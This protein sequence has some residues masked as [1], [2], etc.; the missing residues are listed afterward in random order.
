MIKQKSKHR[1]L[2]YLAIVIFIIAFFLYGTVRIVN[3]PRTLA[4]ALKIANLKS[5]WK[6]HLEKF[7][8]T[9][10]SHQIELKNILSTSEGSDK[11]V[12]ASRVFIKYNPWGL[13]R[14]KI[15]IDNLE[16]QNLLLNL[17]K[18]SGTASFKEHKRLN[19]TKLVLL[20]NIELKKCNINDLTMLFRADNFLNAKNVAL[21][22]VPHI[23]GKTELSVTANNIS[24]IV[25]EEKIFAETISID[26][27][28]NLSRWLRHFPYINSISGDLKL[29]NFGMND[30]ISE[31]MDAH[32]SFSDSELELKDFAISIKGKTLNGHL[33]ANTNNENFDLGIDIAKPIELPYI[34]RQL[35]TFD[36]GGNLSAEIV[37]EGH[38]FIPSQTNGVGHIKIIHQFNASPE[39]PI[40]TVTDVAWAK[41]TISLN[42]GTVKALA[43][44]A[45]FSG[46]IDVAKKNFKIEA[47]GE[48]FPIELVFD[49]FTEPHL[50]KI[51]G[52]TDFH[53]SIEGWGKKFSAKITG[54]TF[55][56][57]WQPF[58]VERIEAEFEATY[59][60]LKLK[61][62]IFSDTKKTGNALLT[63]K[64]GPKIGKQIRHKQVDF[65]ASLTDH[66]CKKSLSALK[67][68]GTGTGKIKI[69]GPVTSI[70]GESEGIITKGNWNNIPFERIAT[71]FDFSNHTFLFSEMDLKIPNTNNISIP[72][73][74]AGK[75]SPDSVKF[76]GSLME[77]S[78]INT[79]YRLKDKKWLI[80]KIEWND[81]TSSDNHLVLGGS[82]I[83]GGAIDMKIR[84]STDIAKLFFIS[85][86]ARTYSGMIDT[87]ITLRGS[88]S[89]P[90]PHGFITFHNN[91]LLPRSLPLVLE[92]LEG[93]IKLD[94]ARIYLDN[95]RA[96]V[97]DGNLNFSGY[98]DHSN[99]K[100][101]YFDVQVA[102][103]AMRYRSNDGTLN[104]E[105]DGSIKLE[106]DA[107]DPILKG[108]MAIQ[109]GRYT[110]DF[111]LIDAF[112]GKKSEKRHK[113]RDE[114]PLSINPRLDLRVSNTGDLLIRNNVGDIWL[115]T[116]IVVKGT[117]DKPIIAGTV[118]TQEGKIHYLGSSFDITRGFVEFREKYKEPYLEVYA[119]KEINAYNINLVLHGY[120]DNLALDLSATSP[121]GI[122]EKRDVVS[123]MLFGATEQ[124][125]IAQA[126]QSGSKLPTSI[127]A[128]SVAG[129]LEKPVLKL[130]HFDI[131]RLEA[132]DPSKPS[133]SRLSLG[134]QVTD[135]LT[136]SLAT[137]LTEDASVQTII[138]EYLLTDNILLQGARST[139]D[140]FRFSGALR[141]RLR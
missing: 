21:S 11:K 99:F 31:S 124:E 117:K 32:I 7:S 35:E 112:G 138:A 133:I 128:Q 79:T 1:G 111:N 88:S 23:F 48:K 54:T 29:L 106:G 136:F 110:K 125:R 49:K 83:S 109:D 30:L 56:G 126:A 94:G 36:T 13:L 116:D 129:V 131:F 87:D 86:F 120:I 141:F 119:E 34:G 18:Y 80:E 90:T 8:W 19:I 9:P 45:K 53:G 66:P 24:Q 76:T 25:G 10:T 14:G 65:E 93:S 17:P 72:G 96:K 82:L 68:D 61:G 113:I 134:K 16:I 64:Y 118:S 73:T 28:T 123:L 42:N 104:L 130:T 78:H 40:E 27:K 33:N 55:D 135:R 59:D 98:I 139:D 70:K 4:H 38:G 2:K 81:P 121:S 71:K 47:K 132:A 5:P 51:F 114:S 101:A 91:T 22:L 107:R 140:N 43:N 15:V 46:A 44:S 60:L 74:I 52:P 12:S 102:G 85:P 127:V 41:G 103:T 115:T 89:N 57:G 63:I 77:G 62:E 69:S 100:P 50:K 67:L 58:S 95:V 20:K 37:L 39:T 3:D 108:H 75:I 97:E 92:N 84:G 105:F 137:D 6:I 26:T 122:L